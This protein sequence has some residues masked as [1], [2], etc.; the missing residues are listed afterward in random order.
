MENLINQFENEP[1]SVIHIGVGIILAIVLITYLLKYS[2][3]MESSHLFIYFVGG[4][5]A[6]ILFGFPILMLVAVFGIPIW[7]MT[8]IRGK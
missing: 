3:D 2:K 5:L 1:Y 6:L 8:K 7:I 4:S